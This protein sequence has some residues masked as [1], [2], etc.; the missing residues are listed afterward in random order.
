VKSRS[1]V[2]LVQP[3]PSVD[4]ILDV[5]ETS[6]GW[7]GILFRNNTICRVRFGFRSQKE[8]ISAFDQTGDGLDAE[9][10]RPWRKLFEDYSSGNRVS[11]SRL[12][13]ETDWMSPF[14]TRVIEACRGIPYGFTLTYGQL[15]ASAGS[16][17][18]ARAVGSIMRTNRFPI[19]V[20]C[21]RVIG[22]NN[23]GGFSASRGVETKR[24]LLK[25]ERAID[26]AGQRLLFE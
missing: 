13:L 12:K 9:K 23:L 17:G 16:P 25:M 26:S 1:S 24:R 11:F 2:N 10:S 14:Q 7:F 18:A 6:I 22:Q 4:L 20:P 21:H 5:F 8:A 3:I 19:I 15:A